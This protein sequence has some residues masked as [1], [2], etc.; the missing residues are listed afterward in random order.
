MARPEGFEP[1]TLRSE[2]LSNPQSAETR[3]KTNASS[4]ASSDCAPTLFHRVSWH[5]GNTVG[6][7]LCCRK[8]IE[9]GAA[10]LPK[11]KFGQCTYCGRHRKLADDHIPPKS[12]FGKPRPPDL[13]KIP[14]CGPCNNQASKDDEYFK[15]VLVFKVALVITRKPSQYGHRCFVHYRWCRRRDSRPLC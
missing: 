1:P 13:I 12:L 15:T 9:M 8:P 11:K 7:N 4:Q 10:G 14:S 3:E 6:N 5:Y 2:V